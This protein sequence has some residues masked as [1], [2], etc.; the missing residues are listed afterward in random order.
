MG[1]S[2]PRS[3]YERSAVV[4]A[5]ALL[6]AR[7]VRCL[8]GQRLA[9]IILETEAYQGEEDLA[10]HARAGL[11]PRTQVM[12]GP[13]GHAYV[14]FTYGVHWMLNVVT[15]PEKT[16]AAVLIRGMQPVEGLEAIA[17][18]RPAATTDG[19]AKLTQ[20]LAITGAQNGVDLCDPH[21]ELWIEP[22]EPVPDEQVTVGPRVGIASVPEPWRSIPWRFLARPAA[23]P[24]WRKP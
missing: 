16:P 14:Y 15:E 6:G 8:G 12:Y 11:T 13:A 10:C 4:V 3:F 17:R 9:G 5:R 1:S 21:G 2:L 23:A 7:L 22:G 19:P 24:H 18:L 20:A